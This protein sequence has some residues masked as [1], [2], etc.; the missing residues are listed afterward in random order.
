[1]RVRKNPFLGCVIG[2]SASA[3]PSSCLCGDALATPTVSRPHLLFMAFWAPFKAASGLARPL[4][5]ISNA[6]FIE[7]QNLPI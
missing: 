2:A 5:A 6:A 1:M 4:V 7:L 3:A